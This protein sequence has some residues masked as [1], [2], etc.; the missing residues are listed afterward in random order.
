MERDYSFEVRLT[1]GVTWLIAINT[2]IFLFI[3]LIG[4]FLGNFV[5]AVAG[6]LVLTPARLVYNVAIWQLFTHIFI[7]L[8]VLTILFNMLALWMFGTSLERYWGTRKFIIYYF[9]TGIGAGITYTIFCFIL[10]S[11]MLPA[12]GTTGV[13]FGLLLAFGMIYP[14]TMILI[15]LLFPLKA[16]YAV[17]IFGAVEF[18]IAFNGGIYS[19]GYLGGMAFGYIYIKKQAFFDDLLDMEKRKKKKLEQIVVKREE[20]YEKIQIEADRILEKISLYGMEKIS[21]KEKR[22]LDKASKLLQQKE[23]NIIDLDD[24]RKYWK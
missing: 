24:Y 21:E 3:Q 1:P 12:A 16:K 22:I 13:V 2:I 17:M 4:P 5:A 11:T 15:L 8:D 18:L 9:I 20:D 14:D 10:G 7:H 19:I 6:W 23:Q